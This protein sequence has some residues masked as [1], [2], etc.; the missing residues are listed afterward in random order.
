MKKLQSNINVQEL[1]QE[2]ANN[3][4]ELAL[5][6]C[7]N[8]VENNITEHGMTELASEWYNAKKHFI[9]MFGGKTSVEI[10][11]DGEFDESDAEVIYSE[12]FEEG[13]MGSAIMNRLL[14]A[15]GHK[16]ISA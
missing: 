10:V 7:E 14:K 9:E 3:S 8:D 6:I 1:I 12:S 5:Q 4:Y 2:S 16:I 13:A 15:A 11:V